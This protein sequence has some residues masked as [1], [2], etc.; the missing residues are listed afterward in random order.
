MATY[1][2]WLYI[3][4]KT[5]IPGRKMLMLPSRIK[6]VEEM[7]KEH[8]ALIIQQ[9]VKDPRLGFVTVSEV[10]VSKDLHNANIYIIAHEETEK[11]I[12]DVLKGL[13]AANGFIRHLLG[14]RMALRFLP[15]LKFH[16]DKAFQQADRIEKLI[17]KIHTNEKC[18]M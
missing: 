5:I 13:E 3:Q 15:C 12:Q 6:R 2:L 7:M 4:G 1:P 16:Y 8:I 10:K 11:H 17:Q 18:N 9:D 14:E